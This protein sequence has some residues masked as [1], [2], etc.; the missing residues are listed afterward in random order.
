M[1]AHLTI[2]S[3]LQYLLETDPL[4]L[5]E[6]DITKIVQHYRASRISWEAM[7]A[8]PKTVDRFRGPATTPEKTEENFQSAIGDLR[9]L[10]GIGKE[11]DQ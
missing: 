9:N 4:H 8:K 1:P 7:E 11:E 10:L 6:E 3:P 5:T 2:E